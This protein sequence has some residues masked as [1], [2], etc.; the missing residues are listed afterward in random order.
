MQGRLEVVE[1]VS[2]DLQMQHDHRRL[3]Q[4]LEIKLDL[5]QLP[6]EERENERERERE[7]ETRDMELTN[8]LKETQRISLLVA[9]NTHYQQLT[10]FRCIYLRKGKLCVSLLPQV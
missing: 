4:S 3:R 1:A 6:K 7:R 9:V 8:V 10:H 2:P 5:R